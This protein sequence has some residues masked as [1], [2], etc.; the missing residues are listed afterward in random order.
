M[1]KFVM[2]RLLNELSVGILLFSKSFLLHREVH[3]FS[4]PI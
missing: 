1:P 3:E 4:V 2:C